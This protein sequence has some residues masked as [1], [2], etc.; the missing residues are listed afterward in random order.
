MP[1]KYRNIHAAFKLNGR[2]LAYDDL[3]EVGHN[4]V[5]EGVDHEAHLGQFLLDWVDQ[6]DHVVVP[7]SGSTGQP[8]SIALKKEHMVVSAK[9]TGQFFSLVPGNNAL[10]CLSPK[11]I[12]GKMMLVRAMVL[13]LEITVVAPSSNPLEDH[14][15]DFNFCAMVPMQVRG[16]LKQL[17]R[18]KILLIGGAHLSQSLRT[19]LQNKST[20]VF[21]TYGMTETITH[22]AA[23][24]VNDPQLNDREKH[25]FKTLPNIAVGKDVRGCLVINAP[26]IGIV[27]GKTND[28][29]QL[30]SKTEFEWLG[31]IDHVVNSGGVKLI[32]EQIEI[33][34]QEF[35]SERYFVT[36]I[37][38]EKLGQKLVLIIEA[39]ALPEGLLQ[40]LGAI[41]ELSTYE[42]PKLIWHSPKFRETESGKVDKKA[43]LDDIL[44][45]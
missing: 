13:G 18:I 39:H 23:R 4:L 35:I 5:K 27:Q 29:V 16:S 7:T 33:K 8:K 28:L 21:E 31:R 9:V 44:N 3:T 14:I 11:Y 45:A 32:P 41:P 30:I 38:D 22:I 1:P 2:S 10:L 17:N 43:T 25:P 20:K 40:K 15:G 6:K 36:G 26:R 19:L 34:L 42:V 12:A 37:A 24:W